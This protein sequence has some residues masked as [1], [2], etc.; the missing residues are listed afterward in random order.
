MEIALSVVEGGIYQLQAQDG[1]TPN[2]WQNYE[3][4]FTATT[5][6]KT[7]VLPMNNPSQRGFFRFVRKE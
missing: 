7:Y 3:P 5:T 2:G 6:Q 1:L 4:P